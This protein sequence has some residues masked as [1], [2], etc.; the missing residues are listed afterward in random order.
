VAGRDGPGVTDAIV[1]DGLDVQATPTA[2]TDAAI[3]P[4]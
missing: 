2:K 3:D 1:A 4:R